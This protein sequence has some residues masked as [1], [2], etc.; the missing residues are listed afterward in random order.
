MGIKD[1]LSASE[2]VRFPPA[3]RLSPEMLWKAAGPGGLSS[4][5]PGRAQRGQGWSGEPCNVEPR[6][7]LTGP[8]AQ[9]GEL[10]RGRALKLRGNVQCL[11]V[12]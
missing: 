4:P 8:A 12:V 2:T 9:G 10:S 7:A 5:Y 11:Y 1:P 6:I 3:T